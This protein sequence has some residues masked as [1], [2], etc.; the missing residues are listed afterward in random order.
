MRLQRAAEDGAPPPVLV[1]DW[2]DEA[3]SEM[4]T[5]AAD[6]LVRLAPYASLVVSTRPAA[7]RAALIEALKADVV[8]DLDNPM[9][10]RPGRAAL[11]HQGSPTARCPA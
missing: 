7:T 8:V 9:Y 6:L 3:R 11:R 10:Q 5:I 2:L 1:V 4:F